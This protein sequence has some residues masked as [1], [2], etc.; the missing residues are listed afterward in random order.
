MLRRLSC[1]LALLLLTA[2]LSVAPERIRAEGLEALSDAFLLPELFE[3]MAEEGRQS[4][5]ADEAQAGASGSMIARIEA[6]Y[7]PERMRRAFEA[8]LA[9]ELG[10]RPDLIADALDF[11]RTDLGARVM[12]L[13]ISARAA[14]LE[15]EIDLVAREVLFKVREGTAPRAQMERFAKVQER[16]AANDLVE[17]NVSLGLNTSYA[18]Y[19]GLLAED[20]AAGLSADMLLELVWA[21]E[22][23]IRADIEDWIESYFLLAYRPLPPEEMEALLDYVRTPLAIEFNRALFRAFDT[24]FSEISYQVGVATGQEMW[25]EDL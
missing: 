13:E 22:P 8:A 4:V 9:A 10:A 25:I 19:R 6:I 17:L 3:I 12:R 18:Y 11:A 1:G 15:D 23:D 14:L 7:E 16:I 5:L 24:V 2:A 21:Q 20:A